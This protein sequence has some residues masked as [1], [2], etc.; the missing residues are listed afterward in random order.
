MAAAPPPERAF[1]EDDRKHL[2][3][4]QGVIARLASN[5][6]LVKGWALT[7]AAAILG[8]AATHRQLSIALLGVAIII[9]F[10]GLDAYFLRQERLFRH[11]WADAV[12]RP[13]RIS[14]YSLNVRPYLDEVKYFHAKPDENGRR[15]PGTAFSPPIAGLYGM[16]LAVAVIIAIASGA[17]S[18]DHHRKAQPQQT[19]SAAESSLL[20]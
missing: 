17:A 16:L 11:L 2:D 3:L 15:R 4:I 5:Q 12:S 9:G 14:V 10:A 6:F 8:Y 1:S 7:V 19:G 20:R 18:A 13:R